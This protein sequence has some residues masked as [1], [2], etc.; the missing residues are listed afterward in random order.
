MTPEERDD[1]N[2]DHPD[3]LDTDLL[4]NDLKKLKSGQSVDIP[5]YDFTTHSRTKETEHITAHRIV[6]VE[7]S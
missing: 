7:V 6:L 4:L 5:T 1:H 2:F 3:S